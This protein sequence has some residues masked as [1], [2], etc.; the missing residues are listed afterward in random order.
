MDLKSGVRMLEQH[1]IDSM[2]RKT[3]ANLA[4]RAVRALF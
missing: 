1:E 3:W 2:P 4:V